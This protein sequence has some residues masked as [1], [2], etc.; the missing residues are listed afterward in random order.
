MVD[1]REGLTDLA[2]D[3]RGIG[4]DR[5]RKR[6]AARRRRRR[7]LGGATLVVFVMLIGSMASF[8]VFGGNDESGDDV[9]VGNAPEEEASWQQL[10]AGPL[11]P[12]AS[13]HAFAVGDDVVVFGGRD[14]GLCPANADCSR[15][16][17]PALVDGAAFNL[18]TWEWR[19]IADV[20]TPLDYAEG[21]VLG[22][23]LYVF[24]GPLAG[25]LTFLSFD[26]RSDDWRELPTPPEPGRLI[27]AGE[28]LVSYSPA[29]GGDSIY[30]PETNEW[31][32][33]PPSPLDPS[34]ERAMVGT[35][36]ELVLLATAIVP[37]PN[38]EQPSLLEVASFDLDTGEWR[39][40][41]DPEV[42][43]GGGQWFS[44]NGLVVNPDTLSADGGGNTWGRSY[45]Y[46]GIFD[47]R[48]S[49][50]SP[51]PT[52]PEGVGDFR[53]HSVAGTTLVLNTRGHILEVPS[54]EWLVL[55]GIPGAPDDGQAVTFAGDALVAWGGATWPLGQGPQLSNDGWIWGAKPPEE[56]PEEHE[57]PTRT[58]DCPDARSV[59]RATERD[60]LPQEGDTEQ[61]RVEDVLAID[62]ETIETT[63]NAIGVR[64][65]PRNGSVWFQAETGEVVIRQDD[66]YHL[67]VVIAS[68]E[69]C[70]DFPSFFNGV[71]LVFSVEP[72]STT[73]EP[74]ST[75]TTSL[76]AASGE[77]SEGFCESWAEILQLSRE[78]GSA[79]YSE[80]LGIAM[81]AAA[82]QAPPDLATKLL[83]LKALW[84]A[85]APGGTPG[86][87]SADLMMDILNESNALCPDAS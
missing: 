34:R 59:V 53:S 75:A 19:P 25:P 6:A 77:A 10:P 80:E 78:L 15:P 74:N 87:A 63:Y 4:L 45:P 12:R 86:R 69:D 84:E 37:N 64:A 32:P 28:E 22:G 27:A 67:V 51:L 16:T 65:E 41:G 46:G 50:L 68:E 21:A 5:V 40:L 7:L 52:S 60:V 2:G 43:A 76:P 31:R 57:P 11:S 9:E 33:L 54:R 62:G 83:D 85:L 49:E 18:D 58:G 39:Q 17:T 81:E 42:L 71:P 13:A 72:G 24:G 20:P 36:S 44:V 47:P 14:D 66:D 35:G 70:P 73:A 30:D 3:Q 8:A 29:E 48:T 82:A 55:P 79:L 23:R 61:S 56:E 1:L 38:S 26:P